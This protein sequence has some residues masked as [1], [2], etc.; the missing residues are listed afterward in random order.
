MFNV[1]KYLSRFKL[2]KAAPVTGTSSG[3]TVSTPSDEVAVLNPQT[4]NARVSKVSDFDELPIY[5]GVLTS[6]G[7]RY[8]V[9][10]LQQKQVA[11]VSTG[12]DTAVLVATETFLGTV[13]CF[14][15]LARAR[16]G[17]TVVSNQ[18]IADSAV[19]ALIYEKEKRIVQDNTA[20]NT[21]KAES[22]QLFESLIADAINERTN[23]LHVLIREETS[24]VEFRIDGLK[25]HFK[26]YPSYMLDEAVG[27]A[28]NKLAGETSRSHP[29]YNG[30]L[31]QSCS[32]LLEN[33]ANRSLKLR[34]QSIPCVGGHD[35]ILRLLFTDD[36]DK[37][38]PTLEQLGYAPSQ[39][40]LL[41]LAS[42]KTV[43]AVVIA[44]VTGS[45]KS[46]TLKT[47]MLMNPDR[48]H[49]KQY[50][51]E[52][53][54]EY[55]LPGITQVS[56][57]RTADASSS[58]AS[59]SPFVAAMRTIMRGDPD[60]IM[61]GEVRDQE[62][63]SLLK[64]MVQSGHQVYTTVHAAS[65]IEVVE[66]MTSEEI[67][68]S[69]ETIAARNFLSAVAY[70]KLIPVNC[71]HC[72]IPASGNLPEDYLGFI[73]KKFGI[74]SDHMTIQNPKGCDHCKGHG[75][76]GQTVIAEII[77]PDSEILKLVRE[78]RDME[79]EELYR[80]RRTAPFTSEDMEGKTA[81][82][83]GLYKVA[84]G[85]IDPRVLED[86]YEPFETYTL[87]APAGSEA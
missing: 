3:E 68:I 18:L 32:I 17:G 49:K 85:L 79:A 86:S 62:S 19:L 45:G 59:A 11:L 14:S 53:P 75:L 1:L 37:A 40:R 16:T 7:G 23:D 6:Q 12:Q 84:I 80:S 81:Y 71:S 25:R 34:Y 8:P 87:Y 22:V 48:H 66:R 52:D 50:S 63:G 73:H 67:G 72:K 10:E 70:Q 31:P 35:V 30:R 44:G 4:K 42:R 55:V 69:R 82:E 74:P 5:D 54:A 28:Y 60:E 2:K 57:Q 61:V 58:G 29:A 26:A 43:G 39:R 77:A 41:E 78:G 47:M 9:G 56:V 46:T 65:A 38:P 83:H 15:I 64:T 36:G 21:V 51:V 76:R 27:V 20:D 13:P 24:I 33:I